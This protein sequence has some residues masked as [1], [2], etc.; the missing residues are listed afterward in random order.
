[1]TVGAGVLFEIVLVLLFGAVEILQRPDLHGER[2]LELASYPVVDALYGR[3]VAAVGVPDAGAV[4]GAAVVA[5]AVD[6]DRVDGP[7]IDLKYALKTDLLGIVPDMDGF[8]ITRDIRADFAVG[9]V[10]YV[11]V[12]VADFGG[13]HTMYLFEVLF[14]TPEAA[15][16][17]VDV[18]DHA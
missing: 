11:A 5:L 4:A 14:G 9:G 1:M 16:R 3:K 6:A 12:G 2:L 13:Y 18:L 7:E 17:Q 10:E 15:C 8:R